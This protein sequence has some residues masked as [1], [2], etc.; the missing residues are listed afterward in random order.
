MATFLTASL[1]PDAELW[2]AEEQEL[3]MVESVVWSARLC[4]IIYLTHHLMVQLID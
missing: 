2:A 4:Q 3:E 1:R